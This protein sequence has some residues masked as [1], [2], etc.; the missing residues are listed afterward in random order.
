M[1]RPS[2][3]LRTRSSLCGKRVKHPE[4]D[5]RPWYRHRWPWLL[6]SVPATS[7]V[8]GVIMLTLALQSDDGLVADD[9]YKQGLGI[10]QR[11]DRQARAHQLG[12]RANV[13]V[14]QE[15]DAVRVLLHGQV[16]D[17]GSLVLRLVH[18]TRAGEDQNIELTHLGGQVYQGSLPPLA[19]GRWH[20][21]LENQPESTWRLNGVWHTEEAQ[22]VLDT[23]Q[24]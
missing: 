23:P 19:A 22:F 4:D 9:Y 21:V 5:N 7:A 2:R 18:P 13:S 15:R 8:L 11:L 16:T 1:I 20:I 10:N 24:D 14:N 3:R 17:S 12:L 6:I